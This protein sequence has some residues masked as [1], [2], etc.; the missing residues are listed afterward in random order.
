MTFGNRPYIERF[1]PN[2][3]DGVDLK[4]NKVT[5]QDLTNL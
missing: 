5:M 3:V 2:L 4:R 1:N